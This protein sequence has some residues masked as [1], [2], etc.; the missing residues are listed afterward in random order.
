MKTYIT[1]LNIRKSL[2]VVKINWKEKG[3]KK[4]VK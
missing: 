4:E 3:K 1:K 2:I